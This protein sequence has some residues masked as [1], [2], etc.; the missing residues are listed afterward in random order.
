[1]VLIAAVLTAGLFAGNWLHNATGVGDSWQDRVRE[2]WGGGP[3]GRTV[4]ELVEHQQQV[5]ACM[6]TAERGRAAYAFGGMI[7]AAVAAVVVLVAVP[8]VIGRRRRLRPLSP[9]LAP[10]AERA[11][12]LAERMGTRGPP[13]LL[14]G[15]TNLRDAFSFGLPHR[16]RVALPPKLAVSFRHPAVLD[17]VLAHELAHVTRHDVTYAWLARTVWYAIV[18]VLAL[19]LVISAVHGDLSLAGDFLWRAALLLAVVRLITARLLRVREYEADFTA[20]R[21]LGVASVTAGLSA[22]TPGP[23]Q[24]GLRDVL[25]VHPTPVQ[26]M[27]VLDDGARLARPRFV[28]GLTAGFLTGIAAPL[29][30]AAFMTVLTGSG[31]LDLAHL[32]T[33]V[34]AG[35][36]LG[37]LV[38]LVSWRAV[39]V[40]R[41]SPTPAPR[42]PLAVGVGVGLV[43][44]E[45]ASLEQTATQGLV[46]PVLSWWLLVPLAVGAGA[47]ALVLGLAELWADGAPIRRRA[48][49]AVPASVGAVVLGTGLTL[50]L[51]LKPVF[52]RGLVPVE[53]TLASTRLG[54]AVAVAMLGVALLAMVWMRAAVPQDSSPPGWLLEQGTVVW[55]KSASPGRL[56]AMVSG[57]LAGGTGGAAIV[58]YRVV[59]G[60]A[61]ESLVE[62]RYLHYLVLGALV[63]AAT[64]LVLSI[65]LPRVGAGSGL[66]AAVVAVLTVCAVA[67]LLNVALGGALDPS[68]IRPTL[69]G[70]L[71][72]ALLLSVI[73]AVAGLLPRRRAVAPRVLAL[74]TIALSIVVSLTALHAAPVSSPESEV[75]DYLQG[76]ASALE[77]DG[78]RLATTFTALTADM[79]ST[80]E[81]NAERIRAD[82]LPL[83]TA[84]QVA[85][86]SAQPQDA[87]LRSAHA[88]AINSLDTAEEGFETMAAALE[89]YDPVE[90]Q[91]G[92]ALWMEANQTWARWRAAL[93]ETAE[94]VG[95]SSSQYAD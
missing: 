58:S 47:T 14:I 95:L 49:R 32:A 7:G 89:A 43:L 12:A 78:S 19:P 27:A 46:E 29:L 93:T 92:F 53:E 77:A 38:G 73:A 88:L 62:T 13:E 81:Q 34:L 87:N 35:G 83:V 67:L 66:V 84:M 25:A 24:R 9:Q 11:A 39:L 42:W 18:P 59:V 26:R 3:A 86:A 1:M 44:G 36:A 60:P 51:M 31:V 15:P 37:V 79:T 72:L 50:M 48:P 68:I 61:P 56:W 94:A 57:L 22:V 69:Q 82:V 91:Q 75:R 6:A 54:L 65:G 5:D 28:D 33:A 2:C 16:Y 76:T 20:A 45:L 55:P 30:L 80:G 85:A 63:A 74:L 71:G 40:D 10:T 64:M 4:M 70:A 23:D 90:Y 21:Y 41:L 52:Q 8:G 17:P